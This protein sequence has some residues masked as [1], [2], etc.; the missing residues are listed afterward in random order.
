MSSAPSSVLYVEIVMGSLVF[1][2]AIL[3][4]FGVW[5]ICVSL[6]LGFLVSC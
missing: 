4:L 1:V 2:D 3:V 6:W 5:S